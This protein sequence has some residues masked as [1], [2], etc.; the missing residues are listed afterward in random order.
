MSPGGDTMSLSAL[1]A[2]ISSESHRS[3]QTPGREPGL[4]SG[5]QR[6]G[7]RR[8]SRWCRAASP[9]RRFDRDG[10]RRLGWTWNGWSGGRWN[11]GWPARAKVKLRG[12]SPLC[13]DGCRR[14]TLPHRLYLITEET[15]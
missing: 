3:R 6:E 7:E 8:V 5:V 1:W 2:L 4:Q 11:W 12:C 9:S 14:H 15:R 13:G 10:G